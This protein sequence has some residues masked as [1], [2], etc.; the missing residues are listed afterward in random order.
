MADRSLREIRATY[1]ATRTLEGAG[2]PIRRALPPPNG[3]YDLVDPFLLFDDVELIP[4]SG[5][6]F[7]PHPHRGFEILTYLVTGGMSHEDSEGNK[8]GVGP[9]GLQHIVAGKGIW[10][11]E[12]VDAALG[13]MRGIQMWINVPRAEKGV[14]P[15]YQLVDGPAVPVTR[16]GGATVRRLAG[17][18]GAVTFMRPALYRDV[19]VDADVEV[20]ID[21]PDEW[22]G[23]AYVIDG[24]GQFGPESDVLGPSHL[25]IL[26][27]TGALRV[28][29]GPGGVRFMLG[30]ALPIGEAPRW[31]GPYVD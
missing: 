1:P 22:Q 4:G 21:V 2:V 3:R 17:D 12:E 20:T 7:P 25:G 18:G 14:D 27:T 6:S 30:A 28:V 8:A 26:G 29:A 5:P 11:G 16:D 31:R 10:H 24:G 19:T 13:P 9:G 23:F 15:R